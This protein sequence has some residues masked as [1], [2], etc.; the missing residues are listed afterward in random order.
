MKA[1]LSQPWAWSVHGWDFNQAAAGDVLDLPPHV[2]AMAL[3][4]GVIA[5]EVPA[6]AVA[7]PHRR[8]GKRAPNRG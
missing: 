5:L 4:A 6:D 1:T 2:H 3:E 8:A 7:S